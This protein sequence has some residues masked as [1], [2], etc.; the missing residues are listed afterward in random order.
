MGDHLSPVMEGFENPTMQTVFNDLLKFSS[1]STSENSE[2]IL[3]LKSILKQQ[4]ETV[5]SLMRSSKKIGIIS[6]KISNKDSAYDAAFESDIT[7]P[8]PNMSGT[9]EGFT[10]L[11]YILSFISLA[12]ILG[13]GVNH[14]SGN[15]NYAIMTFVGLIVIFIISILLIMRYG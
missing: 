6:Q 15:T 9:L 3:F 13:I 7:A 4:R 12:I 5:D 11:F 2:K 14:L 8:M 1:N 10:F